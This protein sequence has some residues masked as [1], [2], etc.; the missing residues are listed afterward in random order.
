[1]TVNDWLD[2]YKGKVIRIW[3]KAIQNEIWRAYMIEN[4]SPDD[5]AEGA[6]VCEQYVLRDYAVMPNDVLLGLSSWEYTK[7]EIEE[8]RASIDWRP[9]S[10][11]NVEYVP[12]DTEEWLEG[13]E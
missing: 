10:E 8:G 2:S 12:R 9:L 6:D 5:F 1:M 11:I 3:N 7:E 13:E 4:A